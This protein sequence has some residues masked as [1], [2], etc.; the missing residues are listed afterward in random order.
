MTSGNVIEIPHDYAG[1]WLIETYSGSRHLLD[2]DDHSYSRLGSDIGHQ[3]GEIRSLLEVE[4]WPKL[5]TIFRV[6]L[7]LDDEHDELIESSWVTR[8]TQ[9][10]PEQGFEVEL[11]PL[12]VLEEVSTAPPTNAWLLLG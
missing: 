1:R 11:P 5:N 8:I 10:T 3:R 12:S 7:E 9:L 4:T 6:W 2:L